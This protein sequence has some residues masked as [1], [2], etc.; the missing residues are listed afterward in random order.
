MLQQA[1]CGIVEGSEIQHWCRSCVFP[2]GPQQYKRQASQQQ[3]IQA[4]APCVCH[5]HSLFLS[6][7]SDKL[8]NNLASGLFRFNPKPGFL[9]TISE[10]PELPDSA[11]TT[12]SE[13][14]DT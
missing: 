12:E 8:E 1:S 4:V 13:L 11:F 7:T 14:R 5:D 10:S 2:R 9:G 3:Q 6:G